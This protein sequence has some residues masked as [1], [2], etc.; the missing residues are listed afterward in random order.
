MNFLDTGAAFDFGMAEA[1]LCVK[2][3]TTRRKSLRYMTV[4][5][6]PKDAQKNQTMEAG[7][8]LDR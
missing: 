4:K 7:S 1:S 5:I 8:V 2:R 3:A 6:V